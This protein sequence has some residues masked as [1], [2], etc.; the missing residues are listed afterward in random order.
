MRVADRLFRAIKLLFLFHSGKFF[1]KKSGY[2]TFFEQPNSLK[3]ATHLFQTTL[4]TN[5]LP[6]QRLFSIRTHL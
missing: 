1:S 6:R 5:K 3:A 4:T 2:L